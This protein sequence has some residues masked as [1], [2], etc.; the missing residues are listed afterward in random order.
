MEL[1]YIS[2][3]ILIKDK[4]FLGATIDIQQYGH[5]ALTVVCAPNIIKTNSARNDVKELTG[6]CYILNN[7]N[8]IEKVMLSD[9]HCKFLGKIK[10]I[11]ELY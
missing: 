3:N 9:L 5:S 10:L 2:S 1:H 11:R 8:K 7:A 6:V 4:Q